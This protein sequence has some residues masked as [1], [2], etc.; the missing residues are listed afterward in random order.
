[1]RIKEKKV[2]AAIEEKDFLRQQKGGIR[3]FVVLMRGRKN[4]FPI[5]KNT[6]L[7]KPPMGLVDIFTII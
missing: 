2:H 4:H 1:M 5:E 3:D 7:R 6:A